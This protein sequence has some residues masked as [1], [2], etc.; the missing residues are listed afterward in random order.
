MMM[1]KKY[2]MNKTW[3]EQPPLTFMPLQLPWIGLLEDN[4]SLL[5]IPPGFSIVEDQV[6]SIPSQTH[7]INLALLPDW[8]LITG[9]CFHA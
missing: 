4:L 9:V 5:V 3:L 7:L 6:M 8:V 1:C 2:D